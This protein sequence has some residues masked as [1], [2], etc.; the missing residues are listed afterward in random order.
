ME[1][2]D[3]GPTIGSTKRKPSKKA[4]KVQQRSKALPKKPPKQAPIVVPAFDF[5]RAKLLDLAVDIWKLDRNVKKAISLDDH[6]PIKSSLGKLS[7]YLGSYGIETRDYT[8]ERYYENMNVRV[9][10]FE[11][12]EEVDMPVIA[13]TVKP[14]VIIDGELAIQASIIVKM[15]VQTD[16]EPVKEEQEKSE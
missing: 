10:S 6:R 3:G 15:P 8:G 5:D 1:A 14:A 16:A 2:T 4:Q 9:L 12:S 7:A 11:E 13:S